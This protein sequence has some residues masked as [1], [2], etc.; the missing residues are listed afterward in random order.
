[1]AEAAFD[2]LNGEDLPAL[3]VAAQADCLK[4]WA[5]VDAKRAAAEA[6]LTAAFRA[7][8]GPAADGQKSMAAWLTRFTRCTRPAAR[9]MVAAS[10]RAREHRHVARA[11]ASGAISTSY[12]RWISD[13][14]R[15]FDEADRDA[16]EEILVTAAAGGALVEDLE[17]VATAALRRL[18]PG[19][20]ERDEAR[21]HADRSLTL[22]KTFGGAGRMNADL[23]TEATA[24]AE[25]V[26]GAL[27]GKVGPE[28]DRTASQRR[29]DAL[30]EAFRRLIASNLL[31]ERGGAKPHIKA[32]IDLATLRNLPGAKQAEDAWVEQRAAALARRRLGDATTRDLLADPPAARP[33]DPP[34]E[35]G[36]GGRRAPTDAQPAQSVLPGLGAGA[37]LTGVGPISDHLAAALA[38]DS[39]MTPTVTGA[40]DSDALAAMTDE[41]LRAHGRCGPGT[42]P[43]GRGDSGDSRDVRGSDAGSR[44]PGTTGTGSAGAVRCG[45]GLS[46]GVT[47]ATYLRLQRTML[48][49]AIRV[50]SGPGGLASYLRTGVLAGPLAT[51]SIVLDVGADDKTVP[52]PLERAVRRRDGRCRFPG[53]DHPAELSQV[54]HIVPRSQG[55][56]AALWNLITVCSFHHLIAVHTWGWELRLNPDGT[57]TATG[58]D[59]RVL[60]ET[61]PPGD[62]PLRAA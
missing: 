52:A 57:T 46:A 34:A 55:G 18:R 53:C 10:F 32:D 26:I 43:T 5:R 28:D 25:Q 61:D 36:L 56:S 54:H 16:V 35:P 59:R 62:P 1:M 9:G 41:W 58:P 40:V 50:L 17:Q 22:S 31:P 39:T 12:G 44:D 2:F 49:W 19:G 14:C 6:S 37:D 60:H 33:A 45:C 48:R 30:A 38:C 20:L 29:H 8:D 27:S 47:A 24:L 7:A 42:C 21:A 13:A 23:D 3:P 51:P 11:L 15:R 4:A